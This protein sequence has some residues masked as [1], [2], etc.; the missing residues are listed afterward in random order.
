MSF[1]ASL[2]HFDTIKIISLS[3]PKDTVEYNENKFLQE[4]E[5]AF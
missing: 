4:R 2:Y 1:K 5:K 3:Y